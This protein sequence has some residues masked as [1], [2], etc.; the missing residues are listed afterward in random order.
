MANELYYNTIVRKNNE[1]IDRWSYTTGD[2]GWL[3]DK[4]KVRLYQKSEGRKNIKIRRERISR[5]HFET[6]KPIGNTQLKE[7]LT[8]EH[9]LLKMAFG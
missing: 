5:G 4:V 2:Q 9:A 8:L 3:Q 7:H 1:I 6:C